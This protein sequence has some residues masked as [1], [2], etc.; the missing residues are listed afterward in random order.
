MRRLVLPL[1]AALLVLCGCGGIPD[2]GPVT[3]V[4]ADH[5]TD[6]ST[7]RYSPAGPARDA[8][9][10]QIVRGYLDA[11]LAY[12][13]TTGTAASF[14]TPEAAHAW[15]SSA[16][17]AIY[18]QPE[19]AKQTLKGGGRE[20]AEESAT[21]GVHVVE[22]ARLDNQ[23]HFDRVNA[24]KEFGFHLI[25]SR[26]QWRIDNP[27]N[28]FLVNR[29]FFDDYY[30]PFNT[31]FFDKPGKR[32]VADPIYLPVGD[33][34]STA[35]V[36]SLLLGPGRLLSG[37]ARTYVPSSTRLRTS[38]PLAGDGLA[39]VQFRDDLSN[40]SSAAQARLSAQITWT[41]RQVPDVSSVRITGGDNV[42]YPGDRGIQSV[43]S[44]QAFGPRF[45]D[46]TF[47]GLQSNHLVTLDGRTVSR[48]SGPWGKD[49][50]GA[51]LVAADSD[52]VA[53]VRKGRTRLVIGTLSKK[54]VE[55]VAGKDLLRPQW[56]DSGNVWAFDSPG[57]TTRVR[58]TDGKKTRTLDI[59]RLSRFD[60]RS[61][62]LSPDSSRYAVLAEVGPASQVFVGPV[63]RNAGDDV[64]SL[65]APSPV[66]AQGS[67]FSSPRSLSWATDT[68]VTFLAADSVVGTQIFE[69][70]IDASQVIG[71]TASNGAL[72]P[73]VS[74]VALATVG[75]EDPVVYV[76]DAKKRTW[77]LRTGSNWERLS[78]TGITAITASTTTPAR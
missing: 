73:D 1:A 16:G 77:L 45:G 56:D 69:A 51:I 63:I 78:Q 75:G 23:G 7:V 33:Q 18:A 35:L 40:L 34:L 67:D 3:K 28:G 15:K 32:L 14:L 11:M 71:G 46:G 55:T 49:A 44:W 41:L 42:L 2:S 12:P 53:A 74:A 13:V 76:T 62:S 6:Q 43:A 54:A 65:G 4:K 68:T 52:N 19:V 17:V 27:Q 72:L 39:D 22:D 60:V 20:L 29:K 24:R 64:V 58:L 37:T 10:E 48:V 57:G 21:V 26:G 30:R 38:V 50:H 31:Y 66:K 47:Y 8:S 5:G 61:F 70:R 9:P 36:S 59:G 25:K